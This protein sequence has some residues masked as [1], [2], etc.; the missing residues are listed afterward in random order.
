VCIK[1]EVEPNW[2]V[3]PIRHLAV[4]PDWELTMSNHMVVVSECC[5]FLITW[6]MLARVKRGDHMGMPNGLLDVVQGDRI[7][8]P[9]KEERNIKD[10]EIR[11]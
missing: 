6:G 7:G 5:E 10:L 9:Q 1:H 3:V 2:K 11:L 4:V 8:R